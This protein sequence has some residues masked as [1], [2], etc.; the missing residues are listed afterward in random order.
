MSS[1]TKL[2]KLQAAARKRHA[3]SVDLL[4]T[5]NRVGLTFKE[6]PVRQPLSNKQVIPKKVFQSRVDHSKRSEA[7]KHRPPAVYDNIPSP[8]GIATELL[9]EQLKKSG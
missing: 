3:A 2:E 5:L 8:Y 9:M 4:K 6:K 1:N 7:F